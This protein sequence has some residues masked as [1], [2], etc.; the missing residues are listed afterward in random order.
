MSL[1]VKIGADLK[2][3]DKQLSRAT[4]DIQRVGDTLS[5]AGAA[6]TKGVTAPLV[7]IAAAALK[8]GADFEA[9]M[10]K[11]A[12]ITGATG[13]DFTA[14]K[15][16]AQDLGAS[17]KFSATKA[18]EAMTFLGMAGYDTNE[19]MGAMPGVLALAAAS[20]TDLATTADIVSDA[21][22]AFGMSAE[23]TAGFTDLLASV[24]TKANT[25]VDLLGE[26]FKYVAPVAGALGMTAED[27]AKYLGLMATA[28][29]KGS[30][31]GTSLRT[32][33]TN[34]ADPSAEA[35][36]LMDELGISITDSQGNMK[37]MD[38]I[39]QE[40]TA[41]FDGMGEAEKAQAAATLAGKEAMS[42]L[43]AIVNA[44]PADVDKLT[45]AT[46][47]YEG[48]AQKMADIMQGNLTGQ[49]TTLKSQLEGVA[50]Q[51]SEILIPVVAKI[52]AKIQEWVQAFADLSP[53]TKETIVEIAAVVAAIGPLLL[54][55]G[56][57]INFFA[58]VSAAIKILNAGFLAI[59]G[60]VGA[61]ITI[62]G[63]L[64]AAG[65][66]LYQNWDVV[67]AKLQEMSEKLSATFP[68]LSEAVK[69]AFAA[70]KGFIENFSFADLIQKV[71]DLV[72]DIKDRF[73]TFK[74][75][76]LGIWESIKD[77]VKGFINTII[78]AI[79]SM[80]RGLNKINFTAPDW[81]PIIGGKSWGIN[82]GTIPMLADGAKVTGATLAMIGEGSAAEAVLPLT[83][84][85]FAEIAAGINSQLHADG[86]GEAGRAMTFQTT[87]NVRSAAEALRE[88]RV[89]ALQLAG[90]L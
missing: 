8:V 4:K 44:A 9:S 19:I 16:L 31:A 67:K 78:G 38:T 47:N 74:N 21:M 35:A 10:D 11:V 84:D 32:V 51:L 79:N 30:Q 63:A 46:T 41:S 18:A 65:V 13:D 54:V 42:G 60:P 17:T 36:A 5:N 23:E 58:K 50:I 56:K 62:I 34:L 87:I 86:S 43:L 2:D 25:N 28:G 59:S 75:D 53:E 14:L 26:S 83:H 24:S 82:I 64:V 6:M 88:Q 61:A 12:A 66:L 73:T 80:I 39:M 48:A 72:A 49:L 71:R 27:T 76:F 55:G 3:F 15:T 85:V 70:I 89:L 69:T 77:G 52:V 45:E 68:G 37:S 57:L 40:L 90:G 33:L 1:L 29:I 7:G 22:T 81:V 20:G